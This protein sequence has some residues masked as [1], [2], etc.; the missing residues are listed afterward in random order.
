MEKVDKEKIRKKLGARIWPSRVNKRKQLELGLRWEGRDSVSRVREWR[1]N[2]AQRVKAHYAAQR[3]KRKTDPKQ[4]ILRR[5]RKRLSVCVRKT[6]KTMVPWPSLELIGCTRPEL[7]A[8]LE[9]QFKPGM[10][11]ANRNLWHIDHIRPC[12]SFDLTDPIQIKQCFHYTNLQP[13]W[14][15]ENIIKGKKISWRSGMGLV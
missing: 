6:G 3:L 11:W 4:V 15:L 1:K 5:L 13:L 2:N 10:S 12:A 7:V 8:H 9:N 14:A